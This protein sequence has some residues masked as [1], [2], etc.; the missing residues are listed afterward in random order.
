MVLQAEQVCHKPSGTEDF[1]KVSFFI[2]EGIILSN[3]LAI[4]KFNLALEKDH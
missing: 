1:F 4:F 2:K 3:Q